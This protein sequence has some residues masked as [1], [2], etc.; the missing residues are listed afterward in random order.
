MLHLS[1]GYFPLLFAAG[2][3]ARAPMTGRVSFSME[4]D[5]D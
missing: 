1:L 3:E 5:E 2:F 4:A